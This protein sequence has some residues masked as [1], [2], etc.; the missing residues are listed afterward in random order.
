MVH[1][2]KNLNKKM[3]S[4]WIRRDSKSNTTAIF[5]KKMRLW[6][7][8]Q[9][10]KEDNHVK[11]QAMMQLQAMNAKDCWQP[12]EARKSQEKCLP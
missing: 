8:K 2:K 12:E 3:R 10:G 6:T 1:I 9:T 7:K 11:A 4:Y 5:H